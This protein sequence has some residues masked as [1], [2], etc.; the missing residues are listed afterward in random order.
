MIA[1]ALEII[2]KELQANLNGYQNSN[3]GLVVELANVANYTPSNGPQAMDVLISLVNIKEERTLKN[4]SNYVRD[5]ERRKAVYENPPAFLNMVLLFSVVKPA[6]SIALNGLSRVIRFFQFKNV[7][8]PENILPEALHFI[9]EDD[10]LETFKLIFDLH[11]PSME[12]VNHL[13]GTLGG[14]QYPFVMYTVRMLDLKFRKAPPT[15][16]ELI[17]T[18]QHQLV[19]KKIES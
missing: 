17:L 11:S 10:Q 2:K 7:F 12:E 3:G 16:G 4:V 9:P 19:H 6:Y 14:K 13:W 1:H 15:E 18:I 8:T 5:E